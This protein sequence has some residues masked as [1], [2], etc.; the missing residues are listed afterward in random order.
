MASADTSLMVS[1]GAL[2]AR[3]IIGLTLT[4]VVRCWQMPSAVRGSREAIAG[5]Q[6]WQI[7]RSARPFAAHLE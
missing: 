5:K 4:P 2:V 6:I 3:L 1:I 7:T